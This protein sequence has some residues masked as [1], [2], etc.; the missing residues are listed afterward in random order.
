MTDIK[1]LDGDYAVE[2]S[3]MKQ[4]A[5]G[6]TS[7]VY[8][9][10]ADESIFN[11]K[12]QIQFDMNDLK[13]LQE[14]WVLI[15]NEFTDLANAANK[16]V[17]RFPVKVNHNRG[18]GESFGKIVDV[19]IVKDNPNVKEGLYLSIEWNDKT[20]DDVKEGKFKYVSLGIKPYTTQSGKE[21]YPVIVELSLCEYPRVQSL[22]TIQETLELEL[23]NTED[24]EMNEETKAMI[25][26]MISERI[27]AMKEE[28]MAE[29]KPAEEA[30]EELAKDVPKEDEVKAEELAKEATEGLKKE[31]KPKEE[32]LSNAV[33]PMEVYLKRIE[34]LEIKLSNMESKEGVDLST[35]EKGFPGKDKAVA[36]TYEQYLDKFMT[37]G[38][39]IGVA[40]IKAMKSVK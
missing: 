28:I 37:E 9:L 11:G 25:E 36:L 3:G 22:G 14:Q 5:S 2:L 7:W 21:Y 30:P 24:F 38:D 29:M 23:S 34:A 16:E 39:N 31:D 33:D 20:W 26:A 13:K 18:S 17:Y 10:P 1:T 4:G 12:Q 6:K 35:V 15:N 27:A 8:A 19:K 40:T 32:E